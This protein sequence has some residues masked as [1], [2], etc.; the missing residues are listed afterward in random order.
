MN[1]E[2][3]QVVIEIPQVIY[4][5]VMNTGTFGRYRFNT[6]KA[7][8]NGIPLDDIT[9]HLQEMAD[10]KWN[11]QVGASKGLE[12]AIDVIESYTERSEGETE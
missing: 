6:T 5:I 4:N 7:I 8:R 12:D 11:Q 2:V 9:A 10:D 1:E 3:V